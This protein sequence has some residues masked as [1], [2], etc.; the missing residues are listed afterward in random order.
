VRDH[1]GCVNGGPAQERCK[2][3]GR[4]MTSADPIA[5]PW[6]PEERLPL[7]LPPTWQ[8][9]VRGDLETPPPIADLSAAIRQALETPLGCAPLRELV[10]PETRI[11][12]VM[13]D[14][15]RPTPVSRMAPAVLDYL[16]EAGADPEKITGLFA[17][18]THRVMS[19]QDMEA[20]AGSPVV[21][22]IACHNFDCHDKQAFAH[23]GRTQRGTPVTLNRIAAEADLRILIGTIEPH[24]QAG[25]GGGYKNLVPGLAGAETIGHNHLLMPAPERYN[26]IGTLPEDNPMRL[27]LEEACGMI[28]G[29]SFLLNV[30]L[31]PQLAPVALVA[32]DAIL[33]HRAGVEVSRRIY[34]VE[35]PCQVDVV[36]SSAYP[37]DMELRQAGKG[38]L[39]VAG[40]CRQRGVIVGFLR[41]EQGLGSVSLPPISPPLGPIHALTRILGSRGIAFLVRHLPRTVPVEARFLVNLGLQMLKDYHVLIFSPQLVRAAEGRLAPVLYDD[42]ESL[43]RKASRLAGVRNPQVAI[44]GH[45]G[46]SFPVIASQEKE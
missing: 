44:F 20:R 26:M 4:Q 13:D 15:G 23:L 16:I 2:A 6:G 43:F 1:A 18:G 12:L 17:I 46:V 24:P 40:A 22:R 31:D 25:F 10:G 30:V 19:L 29:P 39:N 5:L 45:G 27:D 33:A 37:M 42:Q 11:A 34:G 35:L 9:V 28:G 3:N 21:S 7:R 41:C 36:I 38:V 32:G 14:A 8:V